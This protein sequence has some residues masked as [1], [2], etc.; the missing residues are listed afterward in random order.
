MSCGLLWLC[1][2]CEGLFLVSEV[3]TD[4][5]GSCWPCYCFGS[6]GSVSA[7]FVI[8]LLLRLSVIRGFRLVVGASQG[9]EE[10][11]SRSVFRAALFESRPL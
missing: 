4:P 11:T 3:L 8:L 2:P 10:M 9:E 6:C 7:S 5:V 1:F